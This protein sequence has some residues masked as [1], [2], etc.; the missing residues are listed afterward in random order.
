M[1]TIYNISETKYQYG[2]QTFT[3]PFDLFRY[4]HEKNKTSSFKLFLWLKFELGAT[5]HDNQLN[6][7]EAAKNLSIST[8]T[9]KTALLW[10]R[11]EKWIGY[12]KKKNVNYL[13]GFDTLRKMNQWH[14]RTSYRIQ[15][16]QIK[17]I[18]PFIYS[19][20]FTRVAYKPENEETRKAGG[21]IQSSLLPG[22]CAAL[23][24]SK[25]FKV[26]E[27][28]AF[29]RK[30]EAIS[31]GFLLADHVY[32]YI[33]KSISQSEI[34]QYEKSGLIG[35]M[36]TKKGLPVIQAPDRVSTFIEI[37]RRRRFKCL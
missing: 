4:C 5:F 31:S 2:S 7:S 14:G 21:E 3:V 16:H 25:C 13:R 24:Y 30:K 1:S 36:T 26:S 9:A 15:Q 23:F 6:L 33:N 27:R 28:T 29:N 19:I 20:Q 34:D 12:S 18:K 32:R 22:Q 17:F 35:K 10:L 8:K 37:R 11:N